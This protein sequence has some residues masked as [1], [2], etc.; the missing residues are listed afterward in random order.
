MKDNKFQEAPDESLMWF[1]LAKAATLVCIKYSRDVIHAKEKLQKIIDE[2]DQ[3]L[4][5]TL[6]LIER[7]ESKETASILKYCFLL[8]FR[9]D[10]N[11]NATAYIELLKEIDKLLAKQPS[12]PIIELL[13]SLI[14]ARLHLKHKP[15]EPL[16][17]IL[18]RNGAILLR[19]V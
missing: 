12:L 8:V 10:Q 17:D 13:I 18:L 11:E 4:Q 9:K 2:R 19:F 6:E 3:N 16:L 14:T 7:H 1:Y 5:K 15:Y